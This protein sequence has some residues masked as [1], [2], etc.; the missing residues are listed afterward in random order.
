MQ[1]C[2]LLA[3]IFLAPFVGPLA[4]GF[5]KSRVMLVSNALKLGG[6]IAITF[7]LNPLL[8]YAIIGIGAAAYS[9]AK[10]G[11]LSDMF[12]S[13]LLVKANGF[14]EGSTIVAILLG[15]SIGGKLSDVSVHALFYLC[16]FIYFTAGICNLFIPIFAAT[17]KFS[18]LQCGDYAKNYWRTFT[19]FIRQPT[20]ALSLIGTTSFWSVGISLRLLLFAW[21]PFM[22][23]NNSNAMPALLMGALSIGIA[24][25][26]LGAGFWID[27]GHIKRVL[28]PGFAVRRFC[29]FR[30]RRRLHFHLLDVAIVRIEFRPRRE[31]VSCRKY[32]VASQFL[33]ENILI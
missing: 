28:I 29:N 20:A 15:V 7:G 21:L 25:G 2:F 27:L 18:L 5:A 9:P 19:H 23:A 8:G 14:L 33:I 10:Y 4:D 22:F 31:H 6:A 32:F 11:T 17:A 13:L 3:Y 16:I 30:H 1:S 24:L 26:A 12:P